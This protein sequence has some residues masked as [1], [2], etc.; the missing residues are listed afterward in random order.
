M[1]ISSPTGCLF[2]TPPKNKQKLYLSTCVFTL[3]SK[4]GNS[5]VNLVT[6]RMNTIL[7]LNLYHGVTI[8]HW[9]L[10]HIWSVRYQTRTMFYSPGPLPSTFLALEQPVP[11]D[12][13]VWITGSEFTTHLVQNTSMFVFD[14]TVKLQ[15]YM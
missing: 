13:N 9:Q 12:S 14:T 8:P 7:M 11:N 6:S 10:P 5:F 1:L 3:I 15:T 4:N 2:C